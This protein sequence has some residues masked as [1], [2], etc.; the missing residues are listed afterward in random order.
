M[1]KRSR[2][3]IQPLD[4]DIAERIK[5]VVERDRVRRNAE[6]TLRVRWVEPWSLK[7]CG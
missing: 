4:R 5:A 3:V 6:A 1:N 2:N 7:E